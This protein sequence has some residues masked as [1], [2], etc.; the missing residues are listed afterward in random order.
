MGKKNKSISTLVKRIDCG[1]FGILNII[2]FSNKW[3][4]LAKLVVV[5][6]L[7]NYEEST[8]EITIIKFMEFNE[9]E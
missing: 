3:M 9:N 1:G 5:Y 6:F 8:V 2:R 7:K 4:G